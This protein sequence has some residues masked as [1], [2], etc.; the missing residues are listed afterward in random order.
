MSN[1][2][3]RCAFENTDP[4]YLASC[5]AQRQPQSGGAG[6]RFLK[7]MSLDELKAADWQP[8]HH[9][10]VQAPAIAFKAHFPGRVG[11]VRIADLDPDTTL[12][13]NDLYGAGTPLGMFEVIYHGPRPKVDYATLLVGPDQQDPNK[14]VVRSFFPG[15]PITPC[16]IAA[17]GLLWGIEP[18]DK[19]GPAF[20]MTLG[21]IYAKVE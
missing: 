1:I 13:M 11:F 17:G 5:L 3:P 2:D 6:S 9:L 16:M 21:F 15:D 14:M 8:F 7:E 12:I 4:A 10:A 20:A 18:G 19:I